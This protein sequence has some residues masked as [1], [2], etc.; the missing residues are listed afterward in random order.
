MGVFNLKLVSV[1]EEIIKI[2][3]N[4]SFPLCAYFCFSP[5]SGATRGNVLRLVPGLRVW[6]EAGGHGPF[7]GSAA[8]PVGAVYPPPWGTVTAQRK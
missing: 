6:M 4:Q 1:S 3:N 5:P 2:C 8:G 7:G